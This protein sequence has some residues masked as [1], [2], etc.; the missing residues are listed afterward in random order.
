MEQMARLAGGE[1][2]E[3][4]EDEVGLGLGLQV[5]LHLLAM[6]PPGLPL[7]QSIWTS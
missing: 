3:G 1:A 6:F 7:K 4:G 2:V 5:S